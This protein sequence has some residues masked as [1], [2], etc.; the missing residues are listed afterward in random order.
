M[1]AVT[2]CWRVAPLLVAVA[3]VPAFGRVSA[4]PSDDVAAAT[5][6][7]PFTQ[8]AVAGFTEPTALA[9]APDGRVFVAQ[10]AGTVRIV[11]D[12]QL[13]A[14]PFLT[15]T[16]DS[17]GERGL[18]GIALDP[19]FATNGFVYVHYTVPGPGVHN[20]VSRFTADVSGTVAVPGSELPL[21]DLPPLGA[22]N[23]NGGGIHFVP[24]GTL[25]I[26]VGENANANLAQR[27]DSPFGKILRIRADG[28]IPENNPFFTATSGINRA[29]WALGLR[30][31][32]TFAL[33]PSTGRIHLN[34]V[35]AGTW[36][37]INEANAAG[38]NF[39]WP[40]TEGPTSDARFNSPVFAYGHN[41]L[42]GPS[43]GCA[44]TGGAFYEG[45]TANFPGEFRGDYFFADLCSG[46]VRRFD[47]A[48]RLVVDFGSGFAQPVD[49]ALS[50]T[51]GLYVLTRGGQLVEIRYEQ[52]WFIRN[53]ATPGPA[54]ST[55]LHGP[56]GS[57]PLACDWNGDG[58]DTAAT[59]VAGVWSFAAA[60]A[61]DRLLVRYGT[62]GD[63]PVCGDWDGD[64]DDTIGV[65]QHGHFY[66]RNSNTPGAPATDIV[67]GTPLDDPVAGDWDGDGDDSIGVF[68][69]GWFFVRDSLSA[70]PPNRSAAY[71]NSQD[72]HLAGDWDGDGDDTIG[73]F[74]HGHFYLRNSVTPGA[75]DIDVAFGS[76]SDDGVVGRFDGLGG[77][78]IGI[79]IPNGPGF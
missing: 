75:P 57:R 8:A 56:A 71:G 12:G 69:N 4:A 38:L 37:E 40:L 62:A 22:T 18:I 15:L 13:L 3:L 24:D 1:E 51:G 74:Q 16:V 58:V 64:G 6:P 25:L 47:V 44:I 23:H 20:R 55:F 65:F 54:D 46:W 7:S 35:G 60:G 76:P 42:T 66:L 41:P 70:G 78:S 52:R 26:A 77:D 72:R 33:S 53:T 10:Q 63:R 2:W 31:P 27:L 14:T 36:E 9:V 34:D 68:Q 48:S 17:A 67:Y 61:S 39:G 43:T 5:V 28:S 19:S 50:P 30:N 11:R 21:L 29:I 45:A 79:T 59:F 32:F 49:L 73:V